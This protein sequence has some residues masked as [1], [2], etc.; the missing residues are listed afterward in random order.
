M[1]AIMS[2]SEHLVL[3][4]RLIRI[5]CRRT[6]LALQH[7]RRVCHRCSC[8]SGSRYDD[9]KAY[10]CCLS[11]SFFQVSTVFCRKTGKQNSNLV[12][13]N[14]TDLNKVKKQKVGEGLGKP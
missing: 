7:D 5:G 3:T 9:P 13:F 10:F 4:M 2:S 11:D 14:S 6:A 12:L 1:S 8:R